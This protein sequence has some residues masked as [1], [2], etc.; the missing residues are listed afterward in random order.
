MSS[1]LLI[2]MHFDN[3]VMQTL[4]RKPT[5]LGG[6]HI[7]SALNLSLGKNLAS[8]RKTRTGNC[9]GSMFYLTIH[10]AARLNNF[11]TVSPLYP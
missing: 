6:K 10:E 7:K 2:M 4:H 9:V 11:Q 3:S 1:N 5:K 8:W